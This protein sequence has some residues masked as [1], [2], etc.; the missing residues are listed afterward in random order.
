MTG[1]VE[2]KGREGEGWSDAGAAV[3]SLSVVSRR[4]SSPPLAPAAAS[5]SSSSSPRIERE[6]SRAPIM[7]TRGGG[8]PANCFPTL[9][10]FP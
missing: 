7:I 5:S 4:A 2:G 9:M 10:S 6:R 8:E 1:S 3:P